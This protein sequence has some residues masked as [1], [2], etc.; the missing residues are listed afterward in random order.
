MTDAQRP[1][2]KPLMELLRCVTD[3]LIDAGH[4]RI[5]DV[6]IDLLEH[7]GGNCRNCEGQETGAG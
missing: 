3:T 1:E 2:I 7:P 6:L 4:H 5:S